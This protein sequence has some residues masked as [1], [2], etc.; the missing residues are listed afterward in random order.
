[1]QN[2]SRPEATELIKDIAR[3][4][5]LVLSNAVWREGIF[6]HLEVKPYTERLLHGLWTHFARRATLAGLYTSVEDCP[7]VTGR[8]YYA[9]RL[10]DNRIAILTPERRELKT[11]RWF[12]QRRL[13]RRQRISPVIILGGPSGAGKTTVMSL[14]SA[15][16]SPR[17]YRVIVY[18][19]R[20]KRESETDGRDY[21]FRSWSSDLIRQNPCSSNI[22][23]VRGRNYWYNRCEELRLLFER[24]EDCYMYTQ[25]NR[26]SIM[27][28]RRLY[29]VCLFVWLSVSQRTLALRLRDRDGSIARSLDYNASLDS[30]DIA[31]IILPNEDG[32]L[33][34]VVQALEGIVSEVLPSPILTR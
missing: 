14:I 26:A 19:N 1:M 18:T 23:T 21:F 9:F 10:P 24:S 33:G 22:D 12:T 4:V 13:R 7:R 30:K 15:K 5:G 8:D 11:Q 6:F 34:Q 16:M 28:A 27:E 25:S 3:Q 31:D 20:R 2:A 17:I 32:Q 29:P